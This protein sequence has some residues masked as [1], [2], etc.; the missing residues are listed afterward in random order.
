MRRC[1]RRRARRLPIGDI[2]QRNTP[3]ATRASRRAGAARLVVLHVHH[4]YDRELLPL[5]RFPLVNKVAFRRRQLCSY[6]RDRER[7]CCC[8]SCRRQPIDTSRAKTRAHISIFF[9][10]R[11]ILNKT[12]YILIYTI[13]SNCI[14][15]REKI[16][17]ITIVILSSTYCIFILEQILNSRNAL[18]PRL[19]HLN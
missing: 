4:D 18:G 2:T 13:Y 12:L 9:I 3:H 5:S 1:A 7:P 16:K 10:D 6:S 15:E 14:S 8:C 19:D 11:S 17:N